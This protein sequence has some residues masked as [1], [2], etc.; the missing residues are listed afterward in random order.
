VGQEKE[1][2]EK[3]VVMNLSEYFVRIGYEPKNAPS[4]ED[5]H[6]LTRAHAQS[7]PFENI[8]VLRGLPISLE[9]ADLFDKLVHRQRGGYCFEQNSLFIHILNTLGYSA[10]PHFA[11]VRLPCKDRSE[12]PPRTHLSILVELD[13]KKWLTDVGFGSFALSAAL[14]W[15]DGL[16]QQTPADLRRLVKEDGRWFHQIWQADHWRD[17]YEF[18]GRLVYPSDLMVANWYTSTHPEATFTS[19]LRIARPGADG[20]RLA[21]M[22]NEL[23]VWDPDGALTVTIIS[24]EELPTVARKYFNMRWPVCFASAGNGESLLLS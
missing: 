14:L 12:M 16:E 22:G 4:L 8:D 15:E 10:Y 21:I 7:I 20:S 11:R 3:V 5:L 18:D 6:A 13:G 19:Q 17:L 24:D 1:T 23:R 2:S 9:P